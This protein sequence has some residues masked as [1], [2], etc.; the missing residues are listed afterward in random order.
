MYVHTGRVESVFARDGLP[1]RGTNLVTLGERVSTASQ[2]FQ[3]GAFDELTHWPV[4]MWRISRML[5]I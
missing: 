5:T 2:S 3:Q 4:W 1:E